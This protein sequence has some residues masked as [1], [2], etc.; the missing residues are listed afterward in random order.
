MGAV[1]QVGPADEFPQNLDPPSPRFSGRFLVV[2][3]AFVLLLAPGAWTSI[4][5]G[6]PLTSEGRMLFAALFV[7]G[8]ICVLIAPVRRVPLYVPAALTGLIAIKLLISLW[9]VPSGYQGVYRMDTADAPPVDFITRFKSEPFRVDPRLSF[10]GPI[11]GLHFLNDFQKYGQRMDGIRRDYSYPLFVTWTGYVAL[12]T[13]APLEIG[14]SSAGR[15]RIEIDGRKIFEQTNPPGSGSQVVTT[16]PLD[17]GL[18]QLVVHYD[19][20][21]DTDPRLWIRPFHGRG[22]VLPIVPWP[23]SAET[24]AGERRLATLTTASVLL[25]LLV[26]IAGLIAAYRPVP[27]FR[28]APITTLLPRFAVIVAVIGLAYYALSTSFAFNGRT[29]FLTAGNDWLAYEGNARDILHHGPLMRGGKPLGEGAPYYFYPFYPYA[30]AIGHTLI[31]EDYGSVVIVNGFA[32]AA[33]IPLCFLLGW[34]DARWTVALAGIA[35]AAAFASI[36]VARYSTVALSDNVF[37]ALAFMALLACR[38]ALDRWSPRW[39][40]LS[41]ILMAMATATRPNFLTFVPMFFVAIVLL[42][43]GAPSWDRATRAA[44]LAG[45]FIIG[46][47]PFTLRNFVVSGKIVMLVNSWVQIPYFL[48]PPG[49]PNPVT[50]EANNTLGASVALAV[51]MFIDDPGGIIWVETRKILFTLGLTQAPI[52]IKDIHAAH[53]DLVALS[54][55]FMAALALRRVKGSL[56]FVLCVFAVSHIAAM[57][58]AAPWTYG[59]KTILPLHAAF[60]VGAAHLLVPSRVAARSGVRSSSALA[61]ADVPHRLRV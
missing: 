29:E 19:K 16:E 61:D 50:S 37:I 23:V 13:S 46:V 26:A 4:F 52:G 33:L 35:A 44:C 59:Y 55:L 3:L 57:V 6:S 8:W 1:Q 14:V 20:P 2:I 22:H 60:L 51:R 53:W 28:S 15:V 42:W 45:G 32:V 40:V 34:R 48:I 10:D 54:V 27:R 5:A 41:G 39:F 56:A 30:L 17:E 7:L 11:F 38:T 25:G 31:G 43:R 24:L 9:S 47:A 58:L 21:A 36:H 12:D 49:Q 18:R